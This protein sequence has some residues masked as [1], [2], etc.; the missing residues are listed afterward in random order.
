MRQRQNE[1]H[2]MLNDE[3]FALFNRMLEATGLNYRQL[4]IASL[5]DDVFLPKEYTEQLMKLNTLV[6]KMNEYIKKTGVNINQMAKKA[7]STSELPTEEELRAISEEILKIRKGVEK[8]L[9]YIRLC[10]QEAQEPTVH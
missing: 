7:N 2:I 10:L 9:A 3:E 4:L 1:I 5:S 8:S 6:N